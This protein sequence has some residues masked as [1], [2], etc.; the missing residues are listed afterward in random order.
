MAGVCSQ[1]GCPD[2]VEKDS[3]RGRCPEHALQQ[4]R[5]QRGTVPT[6]RARTWVVQQHRAAAVR[7]H[8]KR[9]GWLCLGDQHHEPHHTRDLVADD[10]VPIARGGDPLQTLHVMC[11][12]ANSRKGA[13]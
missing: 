8:V 7:A 13:R 10:P 5:H 11:R 2:F 1:P 6:K 3:D 12:A 4:E 9:H